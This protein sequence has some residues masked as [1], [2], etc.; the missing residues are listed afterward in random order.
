MFGTHQRIVRTTSV[1][2]FA[3]ETVLM[4][5]QDNSRGRMWTLPGGK[6]D[7]GESYEDAV[8]RECAEETAIVLSTPGEEPLR[9]VC[10]VEAIC[11]EIHLTRMIFVTT[12]VGPTPRPVVNDIGGEVLDAEFTP[13]E[14][15]R[16]RLRKLVVPAQRDPFLEALAG[17]ARPY[18][19]YTTSLADQGLRAAQ[20]RRMTD[21][22]STGL[23]SPSV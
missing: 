3:G 15:A 1:V 10:L 13:I 8:V 6:V 21:D 9:G 12:I 22:L 2:C 19:C 20:P 7:P 17:V 11:P 14:E 23:V 4:V 16:E 18:Y 5:H